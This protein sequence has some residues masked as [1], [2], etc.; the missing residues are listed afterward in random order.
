[1]SEPESTEPASDDVII[2]EFDEPERFEVSGGVDLAR[3]T[4]ATRT[5]ARAAALEHAEFKK[6][7]VWRK[8]R[9]GTS[10][11]ETFRLRLPD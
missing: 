1:M 10:I 7:D 6:V 9:E 8:S 3:Q 2:W 5:E 11:V 4:Y